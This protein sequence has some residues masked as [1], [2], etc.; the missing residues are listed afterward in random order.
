[1]TPY[2]IN[3]GSFLIVESREISLCQK[4][5]LEVVWVYMLKGFLL[6]LCACSMWG[7]NFVLPGL[8]PGFSPIEVTL[9]SFFFLGILSCFLIFRKGNHKWH[10]IPRNLWVQAALYALVGNIIYCFFL[11]T[12]LRYSNASVI[13]LLIGLSPITISFYGNWRQK[14]CKNRQLIIP[15]LL[16]GMGLICVN[17]EAFFS[18]S[19]QAGWEYAFGLLCG[20]LSLIAWNWYVV[21]N[22]H[23]LKL[24]PT[25]SLS[26]WSNMIGV[27]TF[28]W[29]L[30]ITPIFL[31]TSNF[32]DLRK[33]SQFGPS[34][35]Y[36]LAG[37]LVLGLVCY[38]LGFY[39]WNRGSQKLPVPLAGQLT[40]FETIF[41]ILFYYLLDASLPTSLQFLG[42]VTTLAG[43]CLSVHLFTKPQRSASELLRP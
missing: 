9:G 18:L 10:S 32:D 6:V 21:A 20:I 16:I 3:I 12:G 8:M 14:E 31:A 1:M 7:L 41:G 23:F 43:V 38:W 19:G 27:G 13:A 35:Y 2:Y 17:W 29:V 36:F 37:I 40:I 42:M 34:V 30:I 24:H 28:A 39:L 26:D 11:V 33:Y 25:F 5:I 15:S 22:A 4:S